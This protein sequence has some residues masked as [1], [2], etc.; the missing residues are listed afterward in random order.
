[1]DNLTSDNFLIYAMKCYN[2]PN[3]ILSE[4][5][6]DLKRLKYIKRLIK[7]YRN[8]GDLKEHLLLNHIIVLSNVFG[9]ENSVRILFFKFPE[10]DY[11]IL[12][13]FLLFINHLPKVVLGINGKNILTS[14]IKIDLDISKKLMEIYRKN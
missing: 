14:D 1:M 4:F 2:S 8:D 10:E 5:E 3:C 6:S 12:K 7:K 11:P 13:T 9:A